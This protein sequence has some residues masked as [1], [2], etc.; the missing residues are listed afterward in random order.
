M[1]DVYCS[2]VTT[3]VVV[4]LVVGGV[5]GYWELRGRVRGRGSS[6]IG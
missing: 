4:W 1:L 2:L 6:L 3:S 5:E